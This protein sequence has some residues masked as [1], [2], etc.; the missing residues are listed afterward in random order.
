MAVLDNVSVRFRL[1][2]ERVSG[3]KE[4]V[5]RWLQRKIKYTDFWALKNISFSARQGEMVAVIGRNGAGKTTLL[6]V[7]S[8]VLRPTAGRVRVTG[9]V[10]PLLGLG[11]GFH[12]ELTGRENVLLYG[13]LLGHARE[14][15]K[16]NFDAIVDFAEVWEFID[17]PL[18]MYSSG[19]KARLGFAVATQTRPDIL[20]LDEVLAVGDE[21]FRKKCF[22]R[23]EGFQVHGTTIVLVTHNMPVVTEMCGEAIWLDEGKIRESGSATE[24]V[25]SYRQARKR[26]RLL[27]KYASEQG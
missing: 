15:V 13:I 2:R 18:R 25:R 10:A 26:E 12:P 3:A 21:V 9:R 16:Q 19:M 24:V 8:G 22:E 1:P 11:A 27:A 14:Q 20:L 17:A 7:M 5:V 4:F 6:R 23:M